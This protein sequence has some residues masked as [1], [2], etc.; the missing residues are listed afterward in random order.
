MTVT[1]K[2]DKSKWPP[3]MLKSAI[4]FTCAADILFDNNVDVGAPVVVNY[5]FSI[6]VYLKLLLLLTGK[7]EGRGHN[8]TKLFKALDDAT[9]NKV[10]THYQQANY[11]SISNADELIRDIC[12]CAKAFEQWRYLYESEGLGIWMRPL[13]KL[14]VAL[15]KTVQE[16]RP[17]L[18]SNYEKA[19]PAP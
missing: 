14:P 6:E 19:E 2:T 11:P 10:L 16:I 15:Y 12:D 17:D 13:R 7:V 5:A 3:H 18:V 8:L 9:R 4:E 1:A